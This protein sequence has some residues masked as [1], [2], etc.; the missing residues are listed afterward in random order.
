MR[1]A[2]VDGERVRHVR[3]ACIARRCASASAT[4]EC[5]C[6]SEQLTV[7]VCEREAPV[8]RACISSHS[9]APHVARA[10]LVAARRRNSQQ[11]EIW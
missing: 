2:S 11:D 9:S 5:E 8:T 10:G 1:L 6:D 4:S 7:A 3:I